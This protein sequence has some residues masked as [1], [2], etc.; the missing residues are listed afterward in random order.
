MSDTLTVD[1][2]AAALG[3]HPQTVRRWL[4]IGYLHVLPRPTRG[5]LRISAAEV[6]RL[7][8]KGAEN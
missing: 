3:V 4:R 6:E 2:A 1:Q 8:A 5:W 7:R